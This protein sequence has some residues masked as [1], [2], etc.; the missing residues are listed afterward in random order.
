M[1]KL[2]IETA[3]IAL[4]PEALPEHQARIDKRRALRTAKTEKRF[5][6]HAHYAPILRELSRRLASPRPLP[7]RGP[8]GRWLPNHPAAD[9]I[10][11]L[12]RHFKRLETV[13]PPRDTNGN[14]VKDSPY[15]DNRTARY[16]FNPPKRYET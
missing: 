16:Y 11:E 10:V 13:M 12:E 7:L 6:L 4:A 1:T 15:L 2:L 9:R 8:D 5:E 14:F 3:G